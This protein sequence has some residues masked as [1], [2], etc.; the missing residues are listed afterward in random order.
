MP[1]RFLL[2]LIGPYSHLG[3]TYNVHNITHIYI[4]VLHH[5]QLCAEPS[6]SL[7]FG[8]YLRWCLE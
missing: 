6:V 1:S 8:F 7:L 5:I 4:L 2:S 3:A